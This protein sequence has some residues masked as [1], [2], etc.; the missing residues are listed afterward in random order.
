MLL[1]TYDDV[2]V[3]GAVASVGEAL[4]VCEQA[5][6]HILLLDVLP[7]DMNAIEATR[8]LKTRFPDLRVVV[9]DGVVPLADELEARAAGAW[10][11]LHKAALTGQ[12][13]YDTIQRAF[14]PGSTN[15]S[16][17]EQAGV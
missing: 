7:Q 15:G 13:M 5:V 2:L 8:I 14:R 1:E 9:L 4:A 6:P 10:G 17:Q 3:A 16:A 12:G 11:Y